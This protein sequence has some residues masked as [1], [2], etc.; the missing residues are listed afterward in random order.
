VWLAKA[1][2]LI[3]TGD[4][5]DAKEAERIGLVNKTVP[6]DRFKDEVME[7]AGKLA[8]GPT[9]AIGIAKSEIYREMHMDLASALED[10]L[11]ELQTPMEDSQEGIKSFIEKRPARYTGK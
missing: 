3:F 9:R 6:A 10:E 5:I 8:Q 11:I 1:I 4:M 7:L 2:E